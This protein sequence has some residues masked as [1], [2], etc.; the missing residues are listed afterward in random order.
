MSKVELTPVHVFSDERPWNADDA[1]HL[2]QI[3]NSLFT[4]DGAMNWA[5]P[6]GSVYLHS[7]YIPEY[8]GDYVVSFYCQSSSNI[9]KLRPSF[10]N[11]DI[12]GAFAALSVSDI[13]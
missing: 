6:C 3:L 11:G 8:T 7:S 12:I 5:T 9:H 13:L 2:I 1:K 10:F 4:P